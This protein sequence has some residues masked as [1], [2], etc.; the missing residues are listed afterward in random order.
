MPQEIEIKGTGEILVFPDN[1][2]EAEIAQAL[3]NYSSQTVSLAAETPIPIGAGR[4]GPIGPKT[5]YARDVV[6]HLLNLPAKGVGV[7]TRGLTAASK[8]AGGLPATPEGQ[9]LL[10]YI[11]PQELFTAGEPKTALD[12]DLTGTKKKVGETAEAA[13]Q[14]LAPFLTGRGPRPYKPVVGAE[15]VPAYAGKTEPALAKLFQAKPNVRPLG[16]ALETFIPAQA[17]AGAVETVYRE[18]VRAPIK[19]IEKMGKPG[20]EF[21][22]A[23]EQFRLNSRQRLG[24][25][26][27]PIKDSLG[28]LSEAEAI[29]VTEVLEG[30]GIS[31]NKK[32]QEAIRYLDAYRKQ[33]AERSV[34]QGLTVRTSLGE[35]RPFP[36]S[37]WDTYSPRYYDAQYLNSPAA[38]NSF[39][40]E[41]VL[42]QGKSKAEALDMYEKFVKQNTVRR[43]SHLEKARET[44]LPGYEKDARKIWPR[45]I[46]ETEERLAAAE[47]FGPE[48]ENVTGWLKR[49]EEAG[50][51]SSFAYKVFN[52]VLGR[53]PVDLSI[54]RASQAARNLAAIFDLP[55]AGALQITTFANTFAKTPIGA[56]KGLGK[57]MTPKGWKYAREAGATSQNFLEEMTGVK[58][59][60]VEKAM[61]LYL[62]SPLDKL[63]R[64]IAANAGP[65]YSKQLLKSAQRI[66]SNPLKAKLAEVREFE[67]L[68]LDP[69]KV[70]RQGL[71]QE[72]IKR[73][74]YRLSEKTQFITD[75]EK[76]PLW[77]STDL[78]KSVFLF[79]NFIYKQ[80]SF[81][82]D[83]I[84]KQAFKKPSS[85]ILYA[86]IA[87]T[88][89]YFGRGAQKVARGT[90]GLTPESLKDVPNPFEDPWG[91]YKFGLSAAL[92]ALPLA[93]YEA[94]QFG[95]G[96][97]YK[98][99]GGPVVSP[100]IDAAYGALGP[101]K[102]PLL[103]GG[104]EKRISRVGEAAS[105]QFL[106]KFLTQALFPPSKRTK[107]SY[108]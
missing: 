73:V 57:A 75:P 67:I 76:L 80:A 78:G 105:K 21:S 22:V 43:A 27:E 106:P 88:L 24:S 30:T 44:D 36:T 83:E 45:Y 32:V 26:L 14:F 74:S 55:F 5:Q 99:L 91:A 15:A 62:I 53:E 58:G 79:K 19:T 96:S 6:E 34:A 38:K 64:T 50:H 65:Q 4:V 10:D 51:D 81:I 9:S 11:N 94:A 7:A 54:K 108:K 47:A 86:L 1:I 12:P 102:E 95:P 69:V 104:L 84:I 93:A 23:L 85:L 16:E 8:A 107:E 59:P 87:P 101:T 100:P 72:E 66:A 3:D 31:L 48:Y 90:I 25:A 18:V 103:E 20:R 17:E 40:Q 97:F 63:Q 52:R 89:G 71:T 49:M 46:Q 37:G 82:K 29:N 2:P 77:A 61:K 60:L 13:L 33:A 92:G 28:K 35:K 70:A 56:L 41:Q 39:V 98:F 42:K 68:G